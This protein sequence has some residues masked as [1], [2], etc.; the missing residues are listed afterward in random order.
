[1]PDAMLTPKALREWW[2]R[3]ERMSEITGGT[4]TAADIRSLG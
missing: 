1:M 4:V 3:L 2:F